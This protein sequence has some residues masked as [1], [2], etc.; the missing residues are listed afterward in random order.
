MAKPANPTAAFVSATQLAQ[1]LDVSRPYI[2]KLETENVL[3]RAQKGYPLGA[4]I[5]AYIR[6]LR[7]VRQQSLQATATAEFQRA[8]AEWLALRIA[9][10]RREHM[11][12]AECESM[13]DE[14]VGVTLTHMSSLPALLFPTDLQ[15]RRRAEAVIIQIRRAIA[16]EC[17]RR[18]DA[19]EESCGQ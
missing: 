12:T 2:S 6:H 13:L 4:S 3:Q 17:R 16:D 7:R 11:L 9:E 14:A 10:H 19:Y 8:K 1:C 18:A 5:I 15:G